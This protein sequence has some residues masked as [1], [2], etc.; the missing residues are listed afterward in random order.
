[1]PFTYIAPPEINDSESKQSI[2]LAEQGNDSLHFSPATI[3]SI[4][5]MDIPYFINA[6]N[7][8]H[9][10]KGHGCENS[11]SIP[12][13]L[14]ILLNE[15]LEI[16]DFIPIGYITLDS[17]GSIINAN[18]YAATQ[19]GI[20]NRN[21]L[22]E[23]SFSS[24]ISPENLD[25]FKLHL[26]EVLEN[27]TNQTCLII[28]KRKDGSF[29]EAKLESSA[30]RDEEKDIILFRTAIS[31]IS[32][33]KHVEKALKESEERLDLVLEA[34][35][36][37]IW[38]WDITQGKTYAS[39]R[40]TEIFGITDNN[41]SNQSMESWTSRI[42]PEDF[43]SVQKVLQDH[44][45]KQKPYNVEYRHRH[46]SGEY[47]WQNLHGTALF[48]KDGEPY[49]MVGSIRDITKR[50]K[51]EEDLHKISITDK[52]TKL[53]NR[54]FFDER[55]EIELDRCARYKHQL[56]LLMLDIDHF[57]NIND[58]Y[59]HQ[60]GDAFLSK[61]GNV[62]NSNLRT[63]DTASRYGGEEFSII[64]PD[65]GKDEAI[66]VAE[67]IRKLVKENVF[68]P[69]DDTLINTTVSIGVA[70][71]QSNETPSALLA[72]ADKALY[73]AKKQGRNRVVF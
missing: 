27:E 19:L 24:F 49:R 16:F 31:D 72:R 60:N 35:N 54:R 23:G 28:L 47:R 62:I 4:P 14:N 32:E 61:I 55:L 69:K 63:S 57:K 33:L 22:I 38:D 25:V 58:I 12:S 51:L 43:E 2:E 39:S 7:S 71:Y 52:L 46:E 68:R 6:L 13:K 53:Y 29:F 70:E 34:T 48:D 45:N 5:S 67:R 37:G 1:M 65:I 20:Q 11:F 15:Y 8:N 73:R 59:G 9:N 26:K 64:M 3:N 18:I 30:L 66:Q 56:S 36:D 17:M 10:V 21:L 44:L 42:H 50:K 40:C 41:V